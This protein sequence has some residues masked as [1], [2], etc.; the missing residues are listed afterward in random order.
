VRFPVADDLYLGVGVG[1]ESFNMDNGRRFSAD[2]DRAE[3][4]VSLVR[5]LGPWEAYGMLSGSTARYDTTRTI[6]IS[7]TLPDGTEVVA[8]TANAKQRVT[9]AN[10]RL[11]AAYTYEPVNGNFYLRPGLD[12]DASYLH[13]GNASE[14][15]TDFGLE[16]QDTSQWVLSATPWVEL[17]TDFE[18][19]FTGRTRAFVRG[20]VSFNSTDEIYV[21]AMFPGASG[22][23][24]EFRNYSGISDNTGRLTVGLT[25]F[26]NTNLGFASIGYQGEWGSDMEAH[27]ATISFGVRF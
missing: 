13:S 21:N 18:T 16:I 5:Y 7:G 4:G 26:D 24:G 12:L 6:G 27:A 19:S 25:V 14:G 8:G 2:G 3:L 9:Q 20:E 23:D 15:G 17:G 1:L 10:F 11:G 22:S